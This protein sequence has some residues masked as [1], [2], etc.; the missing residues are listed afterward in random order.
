MQFFHKNFSYE[1]RTIGSYWH[2]PKKE[3]FLATTIFV[4]LTY[5]TENVKLEL[6]IAHQSQTAVILSN[7]RG[8]L[9][10]HMQFM[11]RVQHTSKEEPTYHNNS[12]NKI[13]Y[14]F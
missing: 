10:L 3:P 4:G 1:I 9:H 13:L 12:T 6:W 5:H 11:Q 7:K 14:S 8:G 2:S